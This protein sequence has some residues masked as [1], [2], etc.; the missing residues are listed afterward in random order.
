MIE[1]TNLEEQAVITL[2]AG[3]TQGE[4]VC[5][6]DTVYGLLFMLPYL[7]VMQA[8]ELFPLSGCEVPHTSL[9]IYLLFPSIKQRDRGGVR[10]RE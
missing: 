4:V 9:K 5:S 6:P 1:P 10:W 7:G 3:G 8:K 2:R